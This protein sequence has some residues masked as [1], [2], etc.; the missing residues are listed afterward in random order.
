M[1]L[2]KSLN[3]YP[4]KIGFKNP[5]NCILAVPDNCVIGIV[6]TFSHRLGKKIVSVD[7]ASLTCVFREGFKPVSY[8][9]GQP[10]FSNQTKIQKETTNLR[11]DK[12]VFY[13]F[14]PYP[15]LNGMVTIGRGKTFGDPEVS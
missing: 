5:G 1:L 12:R 4:H 10:Q 14:T 8:G 9:D 11:M 15:V 2:R 3:F 6:S 7:K 13:L